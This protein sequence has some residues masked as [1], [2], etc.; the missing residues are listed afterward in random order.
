MTANYP[1]LD[2]PF[3]PDYAHPPGALL[4]EVI[5]LRS[6]DPTALRRILE[7]NPDQ[8]QD[9]LEGR[10]FITPLLA[11]RLETGLSGLYSAGFW[12]R[13]EA[14]YRDDLSRLES[15]ELCQGGP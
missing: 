5:R 15:Q 4:E 6:V 13:M 8:F 14:S 9:L 10:M 1:V 7:L 3:T 12:S 2:V 11:Q